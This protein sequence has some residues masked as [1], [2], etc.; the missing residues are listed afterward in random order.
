MCRCCQAAAE[1][2]LGSGSTSVADAHRGRPQLA[3]G[4]SGALIHP[5]RPTAVT[6]SEASAIGVDAEWLDG[7]IEQQAVERAEHKGVAYGAWL[8]EAVAIGDCSGRVWKA[9]TLDALRPARVCVEQ[10]QADEYEDEDW[11]F[12]P[13]ALVR[14]ESDSGPEF[15]SVRVRIFFDADIDLEF[16]GGTTADGKDNFEEQCTGV[17]GIARTSRDHHDPAGGSR[18][19]SRLVGWLESI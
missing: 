15:E 10:L 17:I 8:E 11:R 19:L 6:V 14:R 2:L 7:Q 9:K 12:H 13:R 1:P 5:I 18:R 16:A 4:V 3:A